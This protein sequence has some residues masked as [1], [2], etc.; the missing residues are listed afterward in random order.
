MRLLAS[1]ENVL[2]SEDARM[3]GDYEGHQTPSHMIPFLRDLWKSLG[4]PARQPSAQKKPPRVENPSSEKERWWEFQRLLQ[5]V[6][7]CPADASVQAEKIAQNEAK[8]MDSLQ[9]ECVSTIQQAVDAGKTG[10]DLRKV[11]EEV[12][13]AFFRWWLVLGRGCGAGNHLR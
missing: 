11:E 9:A 5:N 2:A 4:C 3:V 8:K 6:L 7:E 1:T 10:G 12:S 13:G